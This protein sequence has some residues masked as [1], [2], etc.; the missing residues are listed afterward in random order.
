MSKKV[1]SETIFG[2][3]VDRAKK[4][5][6]CKKFLEGQQS[7]LMTN[8]LY[9]EQPLSDF[10]LKRKD[11]GLNRSTGPKCNLLILLDG[12]QN[13]KFLKILRMK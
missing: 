12:G 11:L 8:I 5:N 2:T 10:G 6:R 7:M 3:A 13:D 1:G 9:I 4:L